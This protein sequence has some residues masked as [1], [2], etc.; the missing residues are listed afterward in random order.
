ML[1]RYLAAALA[2]S[3]LS[4]AA[5]AVAVP[6]SQHVA[7]CNP[8]FPDR[9][10]EPAA[11][12]SITAGGVALAVTGNAVLSATTVTSNVALGSAGPTALVQNSGPDDVYVAFGTGAVTATTSSTLVQSGQAVSFNVGS[13]THIAAITASGTAE[14]SI[15]TGTGVPTGWGGSGGASGASTPTATAA[16]QGTVVVVAGDDKPQAIDLF[17]STSVLVKDTTGTPIDWTAAVPVTQ[18]GTWTVQPGNTANTTP[19]LVTGSGTAGTA[20]AGV[21]S[22]QGI[23]SMTPV[24]VSQSTA[25]SLNATVVGSGPVANGAAQA[26]S[27]LSAGVYNSTPPTL[28]NGQ[29]AASQFDPSGNLRVL[30]VMEGAT[31]AD[32]VNN[33]NIVGRP[34]RPTSQGNQTYTATVGFAYNGSTWDRMRGNTVGI[35]TIPNGLR[36]SRWSYAA[37]AGGITNT[38]TAVTIKAAAGAGFR[39]CVTGIN[40][41]STALGAA[42]ELAVR[43]GA[44]GTVLWRGFVTT[45]GTGGSAASIPF[46]SAICGSDN[47]LLEVVTLTASVSGSVYFNATGN[48]EP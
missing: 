42:T 11:D 3:M 39:N 17:S 24:Q 30:P 45:A 19:W 2:A 29:Q 4:F 34:G 22:V 14:L 13:S 20:A 32:G 23:A 7:V 38:T 10:L 18:D 37:A 5:P 27:L 28:T 40:Y 43:D 21:L 9:C 48:I 44:G 16:A 35:A 15:A 33:A 36:A 31:G 46:S 6:I 1:L 26:G 12:G 25:A 47:T 8:D 41:A